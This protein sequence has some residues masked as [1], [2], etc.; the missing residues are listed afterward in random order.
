MGDYNAI[1]QDAIATVGVLA[2]AIAIFRILN[3]LRPTR[4]GG[5]LLSTYAQ[6]MV[7]TEG[8]PSATVVG[9]DLRLLPAWL[10]I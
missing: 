6:A 7:M 10:H 1:K 8:A 2:L 3:C 4:R 5:Q 9:T